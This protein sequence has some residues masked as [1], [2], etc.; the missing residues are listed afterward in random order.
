M[1]KPDSN[2]P[3]LRLAFAILIL[4]IATSAG[5]S[6]S[7]S[8]KIAKADTSGIPRKFLVRPVATAGAI[9]SNPSYSISDSVIR[10]SDYTYSG[11][12]LRKIPG[13]FLANMYQPGDPSELYY[14]GLGSGYT[15]YLLD[16]VEMNEPTT[17]TMNLYQ[18][19]LEF[20]KN[21]Q[22]IDAVRAPIY[23]FNANGAL[24]NLQTYSYSEPVPY[25]NVRHLEE[26]YNY[27]ITDGIFS[28]NIGYRTNINLG[29]EH[30]TTDG[31]FINAR[32]DGVNIRGKIR[33][34]IDS[35]RQI[36]ATEV[37]YRT[38][39]GANGGDLPY[40][41]TG[42]IFIPSYSLQLVRSQY[43]NL[44][45]LQHHLQ[46][47]YSQYDPRDSTNTLTTTAFY[48]YYSFQFGDRGI[49]YYLTNLSR[50]FGVSVRG[51]ES[52]AGTSLNYGAE[53][54]RDESYYNTYAKIPTRTR[55]SVYGDEEFHLFNFV[56]AG[57]FGRG[58]FVGSIFYPA[59]GASFGLGN[60]IASVDAGGSIS[61]HLPSMSQMYFVTQ[62]FTGNPNLI[63]ETDR[64]FQVK[65]TIN[66]GSHFS[67]FVKPYARMIDN[68]IY[69]RTDYT[70]QPTYPAISV[71]NLDTREI[72][73]T[74]ASMR[75]TVWHLTLDGNFNY[76]YEK[77]DGKNVYTLPKFYAEGELFYQNILFDGHLNLK[78]GLRGKVL[79]AFR[80]NGFY[81]Q[82]LIYYPFEPAEFGPYGSTDF[83]VRAHI[84]QAVVYLTI[85]NITQQDYLMTPVYPALD[86][87]FAIGINWN[88]LN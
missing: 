24:V 47:A 45:Y 79:S 17:S 68:P 81:P 82:A 39:T 59:L 37:F 87:S 40:N 48:D 22:Y 54:V 71:V 14:D 38:K 27:L 28:Q 36:T 52:L 86:N 41:I 23:E 53:A 35:T 4:L 88:F 74:D 65:A 1:T 80:G 25:S 44:T 7:D 43:A 73:G 26:P 57:V 58:D 32:Y 34:S 64:I 13:T 12:L 61:R 50:R 19:P 60:E 55:L 15:K 5:Y 66:L 63:A 49:P 10:W 51:M 69:Y 84:G 21:V 56:R 11:E 9:T 72:Y 62:D 46:L 30:Q 6:Q 83:I 33:Y 42:D 31:R 67:L 20:F 76:T 18:I 85:F 8:L 77:T 78:V 2:L 16:G 29:F 75:V 3:L 70:N